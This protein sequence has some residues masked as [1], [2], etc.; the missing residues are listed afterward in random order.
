[1]N[2]ESLPPPEGSSPLAKRKGQKSGATDKD[3]GDHAPD[4]TWFRNQD[5]QFHDGVTGFVKSLIS[6]FQFMESCCSSMS[7]FKRLLRQNLPHCLLWSCLIFLSKGCS[8]NAKERVSVNL[9]CHHS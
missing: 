9:S 2:T 4:I 7:P 5:L 6:S 8:H 1:M 3:P